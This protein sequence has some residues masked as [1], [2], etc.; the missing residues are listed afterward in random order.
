MLAGKMLGQEDAFT[1]AFTGS[2]LASIL[3]F[4]SLWILG[5]VL[6]SPPSWFGSVYKPLG[7]LPYFST[8]IS[9][10]AVIGYN[11]KVLK[12]NKMELVRCLVGCAGRKYY[13]QYSYRPINRGI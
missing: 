11:Y 4:P 7:F 8:C 3:A 9:T 2:A 6:D 1:G 12:S 10:G 5:L 13:T